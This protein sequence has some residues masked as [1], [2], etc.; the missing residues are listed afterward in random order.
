MLTQD[1]SDFLA[2]DHLK[3]VI[4]R[5]NKFQANSDSN[6]KASSPVAQTCFKVVLKNPKGSY[7]MDS[8]MKKKATQTLSHLAKNSRERDKGN[9]SLMV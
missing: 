2:Q 4:A 8:S 3:S 7:Q 6:Q 5:N 1:L 9:G